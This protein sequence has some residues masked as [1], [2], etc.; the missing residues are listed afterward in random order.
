MYTMYVNALNDTSNTHISVYV[1]W[2]VH[3]KGKIVTFFC[4][5]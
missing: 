2:R 4:S 5:N 3:L 1:A